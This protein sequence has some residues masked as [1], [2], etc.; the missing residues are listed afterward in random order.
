[1]GTKL[2]STPRHRKKAAT[3]MVNIN[4][5][6]ESELMNH[7]T[8][9]L[10]LKDSYKYIEEFWSGNKS[11][12]RAWVPWSWTESVKQQTKNNTI[13]L[14]APSDDTL[15]GVKT[16]YK[17]LISQKT[18]LY[19]NLWFKENRTKSNFRMGKFRFIGCKN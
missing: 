7:H 8:H 12:E 1:M 9:Y 17:S 16:D 13:V 4:P 18:Q 15:H 6:S 10:K 5:N 2:K 14:F 3:F 11:I 19:G